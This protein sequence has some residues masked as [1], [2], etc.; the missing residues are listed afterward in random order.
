MGGI[1]GLA[2]AIVLGP[3]I[4]KFVD[5]KIHPIPAHH[6]PMVIAGTFILAFGWFGF[7]PGSTLSGT[8]LRI[9]IVVVNTMLAGTA[10]ALA[11]MLTL[12]A[13]GMKPDPSMLCNGMLAGLVAITAP[14]AFVDSWAAVAIGGVA[15]VVVVFSVF[16]WDKV[17][18][19]DP[20]GAISVHGVCGLWGVLSVGIFANGKYGASWGNVTRP[21]FVSIFHKAY[22]GLNGDG[23]DGVR[24]ILFG[25]SSQLV[26]QAI[27][28]AVVA[29]FG[30]IMAYVWFKFSNLITPIRVT[31]EVEIEGLDLPEMG[32]M[33]YPEFHATS[34]N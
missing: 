16:F 21:E 6:I 25:D 18:V 28:C 23:I 7:N 14:C 33:G 13:K 8:D 5:G 22:P 30:F 32:A 9:S 34:R 20:V 24:G 27:D 3:R 10:G 29:V 19:D 17:R 1:I 4:G 26:A 31:K 12:Y 11:A 15:G 2:G